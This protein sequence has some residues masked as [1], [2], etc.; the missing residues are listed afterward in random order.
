MTC[1]RTYSHA[2]ARAHSRT[3]KCTHLIH[4]HIHA[5]IYTRAHPKKLRRYDNHTYTHAHTHSHVHSQIFMHNTCTRP[6]MHSTLQKN[7]KTNS[8]EVKFFCIFCNFF[9]QALYDGASI[10]TDGALRIRL[11]IQLAK[12]LRTN[13]VYL[14]K[15]SI[16]QTRK[17]I[18]TH[19]LNP[20]SCS[21]PVSCCYSCMHI[22]DIC[23]II[24]QISVLTI[25]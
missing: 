17:V 1:I 21:T 18:E 3:R 11:N 6:L 23:P 10:R 8:S 4:I 2:H 9:F 7:Q 5:H 22:S 19:K 16:I 12:F 25:Q 20:N 24:F 15:V 13:V 14:G